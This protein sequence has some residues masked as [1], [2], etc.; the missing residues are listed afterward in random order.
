MITLCFWYHIITCIAFRNNAK[1][2]NIELCRSTC[3]VVVGC[4]DAQVHHLSSLIKARPSTH[5]SETP[6]LIAG[7]NKDYSLSKQRGIDGGQPLYS[8]GKHFQRKTCSGL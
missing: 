2:N 4:Q 1:V 3:C 8:S 7:D 6:D 5:I